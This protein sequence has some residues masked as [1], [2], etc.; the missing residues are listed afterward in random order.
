MFMHADVH[1]LSRTLAHT[2][3]YAVRPR[4]FLQGHEDVFLEDF[5]LERIPTAELGVYSWRDRTVRVLFAEGKMERIIDT[6]DGA[7]VYMFTEE[8][9]DQFGAAVHADMYDKEY[10]ALD[11]PAAEL[12]LAR[13]AD[14]ASVSGAP[15][16]SIRVVWPHKGP[17]SEESLR[18]GGT[19]IWLHG[20]GGGEHLDDIGRNISS[21]LDMPW[22]KFIFPCAPRQPVSLLGG[23]VTSSWF[24]IASVTATG[25]DEDAGELTR[26]ADYISRIVQDEIARGVGPEHVLVCG[27]GQGAAVALAVGLRGYTSTQPD[28]PDDDELDSGDIDYPRTITARADRHAQLAAA[29]AEKMQLMLEAGGVDP[30]PKVAKLGG[31]AVIAGWFP[32]SLLDQTPAWASHLLPTY[33]MGRPCGRRGGVETFVAHGSRDAT[34]PLELGKSLFR[35][36]SKAGFSVSKLLKFPH[37][38]G[39]GKLLLLRLRGWIDRQ[40]PDPDWNIHDHLGLDVSVS[41][42]EYTHRGALEAGTLPC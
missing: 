15:Y 11:R 9:E 27:F 37:G 35:R 10:Y 7:I 13:I 2:H 38:H 28:E 20:L 33:W 42:Q 24:N 40:I 16:G 39:L 29:R 6:E 5:A 26:A 25:T 4:V 36:A 31:V 21:Q 32:D 1:A 19:V 8:D 41:S 30:P 23:K 18:H 22:V 34:V 3:R 17:K 12:R 14:E